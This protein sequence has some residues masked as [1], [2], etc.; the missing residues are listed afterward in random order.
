MNNKVNMT[1]LRVIFV[2][3][4]K[5]EMIEQGIIPKDVDWTQLTEEQKEDVKKFLE[6]KIEEAKKWEKL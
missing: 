3:H 2:L 6:D 5:D 1:D 4:F